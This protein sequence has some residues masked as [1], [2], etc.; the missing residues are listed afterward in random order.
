MA[1][2]ELITLINYKGDNE[3]KQ[4]FNG[5]R[6]GYE[7]N[8]RLYV[9]GDYTPWYNEDEDILEGQDLPLR[10]A[11][12]ELIQ[13]DQ[14][15]IWLEQ[16]GKETLLQ[17]NT[18]YLYET[19][20]TGVKENYLDAEILKKELGVEEEDIN[21]DDMNVKIK[22]VNGIGY[23][24]NSLENFIE[25]EISKF[26]R[27]SPYGRI[28]LWS[29]KIANNMDFSIK[30]NTLNIKYEKFENSLKLEFA[31]DRVY[32]YILT[33]NKRLIDFIKNF[34]VGTANKIEDNFNKVNFPDSKSSNENVLYLIHTS[35]ILEKDCPMPI[36]EVLTGEEFDK[37][38]NSCFDDYWKGTNFT[39]IT[40][41]ED[42][43][44]HPNNFCQAQDDMIEKIYKFFGGKK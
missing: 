30:N 25:R 5:S 12:L 43:E 10:Y 21:L 37:K 44:N 9:Q 4:L 42:F 23:R 31:P 19:D 24:T 36:W 29:D 27:H 41:I 1:V 18:W 14:D 26:S 3:M 39:E 7:E 32:N 6:I 17:D 35:E 13:I 15:G 2:I 33:D 16:K 40:S 38:P 22:V 28:E 34:I 11:N 8:G 20:C